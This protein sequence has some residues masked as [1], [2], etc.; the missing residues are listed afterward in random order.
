MS[1]VSKLLAAIVIAMALA[2]L[3][4]TL[5]SADAVRKREAELAPAARVVDTEFGVMEY[6]MAGEGVPVLVIHGAGGGFDQGLLIAR[7]YLGDGYRIIAPSRFGYLGSAMPGDASTTAQAGALAALLDALGVERI[8]VL[9]FSGGVPPAL[10][11]AELYPERTRCLT[12]VSSAP[13]TPYAPPDETRPMPDRLYQ[14]LFGSDAVYWTLART[15]PGLLRQ[16]FDARAEL[17]T[18]LPAE[19]ER[20]IADLVEGF[21]P[22]SRRM[23]GVRNE[24]AAIDSSARYD[25]ESISA[26]ILVLHA[27]DDRINS[28]SVAEAVAARAPEAVL[29]GFDRGG[30]LLLGHHASARARIASFLTSCADPEAGALT[31]P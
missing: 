8:G 25:L 31:S 18:D 28:F 13:F 27:R 20:M 11:F 10:K 21:L 12:L 22:A 9:G 16:A 19:E 17:T 1:L 5:L 3:C 24:V 2:L 15:N 30:H 29:V 23:A 7:T 26:P 4:V 6:A 14:A